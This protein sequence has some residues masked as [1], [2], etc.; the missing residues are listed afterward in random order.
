V[1]FSLDCS[2]ATWLLPEETR[3]H[4]NESPD[5]CPDSRPDA[6]SMVVV[7]T[8]TNLGGDDDSDW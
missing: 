2:L 3:R 7:P 4:L 8:M 5:Q 1:A 6:A